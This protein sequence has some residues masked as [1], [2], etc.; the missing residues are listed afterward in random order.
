MKIRNDIK[1]QNRCHDCNFRGS[2]F[3]CNFSDP[4]LK[5][6]QSIKITNAYPKGAQLLVEGQPSDGVF[7]LCQGRV[8]LTTHSRNGRSLILRIAAPG[9]VLGLSAA[10]S[11]S[12]SE[13][14]AEVIDPCQVNFIPRSQFRR[15]LEQNSD[16][17]MNALRQ[18][19]A[20]YKKAYRQIRS[21]GLSTRVADKLA[22]LLLEWTGT[23][24]ASS[25]SVHIENHFSHEEIAE[26][27]GTSRETVTRILKDF[28]TRDLISIKG[29]DLYIPSTR[30]LEETIDGGT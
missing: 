20:Q 17:G 6:F 15:F 7:V 12:S 11:E 22:T 18:L 21:L 28:R 4:T 30:K 25:E 1:I 27:I 23:D 8:K 5:C 26:M 3:F 9:E 13:T 24:P 14:T 10:I 2:D 29:A 16:A 19:S